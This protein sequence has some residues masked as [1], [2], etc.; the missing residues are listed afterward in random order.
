VQQQQQAAANTQVQPVQQQS[1]PAGAIPPGVNVQQPATNMQQPQVQPEQPA[2]PQ[3][4]QQSA[5][6]DQ[7][8]TLEDVR[9]AI[10]AMNEHLPPGSPFAIMKATAWANGE[11]KPRWFTLESI[12]AHLYNRF[13]EELDAQKR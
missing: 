10:A 6:A 12:P 5:G 11:E 13:L 9:A 1:I 2:M 4:Q 7:P 8:L 3:V